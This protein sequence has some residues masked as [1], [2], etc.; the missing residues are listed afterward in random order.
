MLKPFYG[1]LRR[2]Y[3]P[4]LWLQY[5]KSDSHQFYKLKVNSMQIENEPRVNSQFR[6]LYPL[7]TGVVKPFGVPC[8][9]FSCF[10]QHCAFHEYDIYKHVSLDVHEFFVNVDRVFLERLYTMFAEWTI[11]EEPGFKIRS[12]MAL[13]H[14][15]LATLIAQVTQQ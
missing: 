9:E 14:V 12:D 15:P 7:M 5:R 6:I 11:P 1:E 13:V 4:A 3:Y 2:T 8:I 10:K